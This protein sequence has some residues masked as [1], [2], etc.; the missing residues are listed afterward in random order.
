[1]SLIFSAYT[2]SYGM[3]LVVS[4]RVDMATYHV[5]RQC[6]L[7]RENCHEAYI[8]IYMAD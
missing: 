7:S 1:M 8:Y 3:K 2:I 4:I 5:D 6:P